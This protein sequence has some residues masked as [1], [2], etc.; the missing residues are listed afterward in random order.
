MLSVRRLIL[1]MQQL[2]RVVRSIELSEAVLAVITELSQE[3]SV[4]E[5]WLMGSRA[6]ASASESSDWDL[7]VFSEHEPRASP[8]RHPKVD[9]LWAGPSGS[10]LLEGQPECM[11]LNFSDF[12][13]V[14][15]SAD[16]AE[17]L[18]RKSLD[19]PP[20]IARDATE[21]AQVRV[22]SCSIRLWAQPDKS[23]WREA[24]P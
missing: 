1:S 17:Y 13:W 16:S 24:R 4:L 21:P 22:P 23:S 3:P 7:L 10:L 15:R 19:H 8:G 6:N 20:G 5:V 11:A 12:Q 14:R 2:K 9:V 18:G